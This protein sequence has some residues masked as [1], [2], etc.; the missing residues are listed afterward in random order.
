[1]YVRVAMRIVLGFCITLYHKKP[2]TRHVYLSVRN[3][4]IELDETNNQILYLLNQNLLHKILSNNK[5]LL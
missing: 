2:Y 4:L 5:E 1:M 3:W